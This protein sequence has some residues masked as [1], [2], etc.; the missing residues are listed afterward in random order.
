[1]S[2]VTSTSKSI[3][4]RFFEDALT[5]QNARAIDELIAPG[6]IVVLPTGQFTGPEGVKRASAQLGSAYPDLQITVKALAAEGDQ[7][8]AEWAFCGTQQRE[9]LGVPPSGRRE[10]IAAQSLFRVDGNKIVAHWMA[11]R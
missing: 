9:L 6:A 11:E 7:V 10:C 8:A 5:R 1:V 4:R 3:A 2:A